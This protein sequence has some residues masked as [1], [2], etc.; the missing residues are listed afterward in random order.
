[1]T[2][3]SIFA[4]FGFGADKEG[5]DGGVGEK[6]LANRL[7][8]NGQ[9]EW[10][11]DGERRRIRDMASETATPA[12]NLGPEFWAVIA[13]AVAIAML[14]LTV[15][16][17][18]RSDIQELRHEIRALDNNLSSK[19]ETVQAD[20]VGIRERLSV[21]EAGI[22]AAVVEPEPTGDLAAVIEADGATP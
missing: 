12:R 1:M 3:Q 6:G 17:W 21:V 2:S 9:P 10:R 8:W 15:A 13:T 5:G 20:L 19:I 18:Q 11:Q 22:G 16:G 4:A 14:I 7:P